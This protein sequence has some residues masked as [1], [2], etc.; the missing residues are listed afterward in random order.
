MNL[1]RLSKD[2]IDRMVD[3]A[4]KYKE[5]D[6]KQREKIS[7]KNNLESYAFNLKQTVEDEKIKEKLTT[8][9]KSTVLEKAKEVIEWLDNNQ[10]AEKD[11]FEDKQKELEQVAMPIMSKIY[12]SGEGPAGSK[13][14]FSFI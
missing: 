9:D 12:Q 2:E 5:Q 10:T 11:E 14:N 8:E 13:F 7:A 3:E 6:D 4:E 1:G